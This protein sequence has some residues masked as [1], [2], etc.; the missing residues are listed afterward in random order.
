MTDP[1]FV[2]EPYMDPSLEVGANRS[3][4]TEWLRRLESEEGA[5]TRLVQQ[6]GSLSLAARKIARARLGA[7]PSFRELRCVAMELAE[8]TGYYDRAPGRYETALDCFLQ[9]MGPRPTP[10]LGA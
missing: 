10:A 5:L 9:G 1:S 8:R 7:D 4:A 2:H 3:L 6:S